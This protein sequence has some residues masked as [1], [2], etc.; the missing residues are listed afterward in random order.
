MGKEKTKEQTPVAPRKEL[1]EIPEVQALAE[2]QDQLLGLM[3]AHSEVF[4]QYAIL[5]E[6]YNTKLEQ[7]EKVVR[8]ARVSCGPFDLYQWTT[9]SDPELL[10]NNVGKEKF[11]EMGG[12][13]LPQ[14]DVLKI[15]TS[16]FSLSAAWGQV[17]EELA[18]KVVWKEPKYHKPEKLKAF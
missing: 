5:V 14:P 9:K 4:E 11:L 12:Q 2:V 18:K 17:P 7:A 6:D 13:V 15:D 16:R 10:L 1:S 8:A 3:E